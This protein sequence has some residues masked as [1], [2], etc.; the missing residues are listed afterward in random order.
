M[1]LDI[2][3]LRAKLNTFQGQGQRSSAFWKPSAGKTIVR[4]VPLTDRPENPF[5]ELYFHYLGNKTH[6]SPMTYGNRDPIA[7]F[8][9]NLRGDGSRESYQQAREFMP[10]LR[11]FVPVVVRGEEDEGVRFWSFG[12]TVYQELL[13]IIADPDY[14]DITHIETG[15]DITVTYIPQEQSDTNFPKT[16]VMAKPNQTPL[17]EDATLVER[18]TT[19]QPDLRSLYKE[20]S[21]EELSAFLKR[22]LDPDGA[23]DAPETSVTQQVTTPV[24]AAPQQTSAPVK[25]A[26]DEFESLFAE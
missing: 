17:S 12:K 23:V 21:F 14:G 1:A 2:S 7:E 6:L 16:S 9:D 11:T 20:P 5:S 18:W 13:Q 4:I 26:V 10:K 15:R 8:A 24:A 19:S 3:A 22:Y 25:S